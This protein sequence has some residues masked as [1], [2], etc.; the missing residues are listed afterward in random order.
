MNLDTSEA[1]LVDLLQAVVVTPI[2]HTDEYIVSDSHIAAVPNSNSSE[3]DLVTGDMVPPPAPRKVK[4][5]PFSV[6]NPTLW[7]AT[8]E[9]ILVANEVKEDSERFALLLQTLS[10]EQLEKIQ[11]VIDAVSREDDA[12]EKRPYKAAKTILL[13]EYGDSEEKQLKKLFDENPMPASIQTP[14]EKLAYI[15][16]LAGNSVSETIIKELWSSKIPTDVKPYIA[17][18]KTLPI[19]QL[20]EQADAV[21]K[22]LREKAA[23]ATVSTAQVS[24]IDQSVMPPGTSRDSV[25]IDALAAIQREIAAMRVDNQREISALRAE[26]SP[27][28]RLFAQTFT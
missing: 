16:R 9:L 8:T 15:R 26:T 21:Y 27:K 23:A 24:Q 6:T 22:L 7:F 20:A 25:L 19:E 12:K 28:T 14:K 10:M 4:L 13:Q 5:Q 17:G 3:R 1:E 2:T 18:C 11:T